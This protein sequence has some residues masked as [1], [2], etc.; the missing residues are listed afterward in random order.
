M[1][2]KLTDVFGLESSYYFAKNHRNQS[3]RS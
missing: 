1:K 3:G 2:M